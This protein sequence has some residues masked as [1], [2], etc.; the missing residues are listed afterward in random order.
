MYWKLFAEYM[1]EVLRKFSTREFQTKIISLNA[2]L[3]WIILV[4]W[5]RINAQLSTAGEPKGKKKECVT[6]N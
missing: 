1:T 5:L 3:F 2:M 4:I 6:K